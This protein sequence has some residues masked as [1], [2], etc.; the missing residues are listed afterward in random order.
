[1]SPS[2][3]RRVAQFFQIDD[4][5]PAPVSEPGQLAGC[6]GRLLS[7]DP[8]TG[9]QTLLLEMPAGWSAPV[10]GG[11]G[12]L[13]LLILEGSLTVDGRRLGA[14]GFAAL[15]TG[16]GPLVVTVREAARSVA[17]WSPH[18]G[19]S[20]YYDSRPRVVRTVDLP[21]EP[22]VFPAELQAPGRLY[23]VWS[24]SLRL[25]D[26]VRGDLHGGPKGLLRIV[27][28]VSGFVGDHRQESHPGC[29][30]EIIWLA[31]DFFM[32]G[33][34]RQAA[35]SYVG[36]PSHHRHGPLL[37]QRG[38]ILLVHT[39]APADFCFHEPPVPESLISAY[40]DGVSWLEDPV[41][42][43]SPEGSMAVPLGG[44]SPPAST[45]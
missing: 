26:P 43:P 35:G 21:W 12:T 45:G 2:P 28:L 14:G 32:P 44:M 4:V 16:C 33:T 15:P 24:K 19:P 20:D 1:M 41:H 18:F 27:V 11:G 7:G 3:D 6:D 9:Q 8:A 34:G 36:N 37:T 38:C 39:D 17:V 25:P 5:P 22:T 40:M 42:G 23:G 30:E 29:W 13:E 31:G 10:G